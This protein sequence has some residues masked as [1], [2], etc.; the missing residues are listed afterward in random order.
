MLDVRRMRVFREV[1]ARGSFSAAAEELY[2]SQSAVSQQV[3]ALEREVGLPLL[4]RTPQGPRLTD[5]GRA[6]VRHADAA[7]AR[8]EQ[9]EHELAAI[10]GLAGG[11]LRIASFPSASLTLVTEA[12]SRF[13]AAHPAVEISVT[14]AEPEESVPQL[15][16]A[17]IDLAIT[18]DYPVLAPASDDRDT[19]RVL[20]LTESMYVALP[21]DHRLARRRTVRLDD[22]ADEPWLSGVR[23]SSCGEAV[24]N[25]CLDAGFEPR[26]AVESDE[27]QVLEGYVAAGL[28][29]TLLPDLAVPSLREHL[30]LRPTDPPAPKRRVWAATRA[31]GARSVATDAM[32]AVLRQ[33][34]EELADEA[35]GDVAAK[36][37]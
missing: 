25:T 9:A 31:A 5:A 29:V 20:L 14:E 1:A 35:A 33:V 26:I 32:V 23:P 10:A 18:F 28:G 8:L 12:L 30:V 34:G 3:A 37:A 2:L 27:Y 7:I 4:V 19:E 16:A 36:A 24:V 17:E 6:L 13:R 22:L 21:P 11:E 15:R